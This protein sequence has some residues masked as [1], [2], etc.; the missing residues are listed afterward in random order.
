MFIIL[1]RE[2]RLAPHREHDLRTCP[3]TGPAQFVVSVRT[4]ISQHRQMSIIESEE[5]ESGKV[6]KLRIQIQRTRF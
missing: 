2:I 3:K 5:P 4:N 6:K 1:K